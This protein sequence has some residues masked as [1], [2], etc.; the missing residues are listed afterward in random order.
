MDEIS[1][2]R[3]ISVRIARR[4]KRVA[5]MFGLH[6]TTFGLPLT[7]LLCADPVPRNVRRSV[8]RENGGGLRK[9][10]V[11]YLYEYLFCGFYAYISKA[12]LLL[13]GLHFTTLDCNLL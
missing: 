9:S 1:A 4:A 3:A 12:W 7:A 13:L 10:V 11:S 5:F 6:L 2:A 8:R